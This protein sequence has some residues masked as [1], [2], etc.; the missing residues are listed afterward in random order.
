MIGGGSGGGL[1]E[2]NT[3]DAREKRKYLGWRWWCRTRDDG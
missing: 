2:R 1:V 3:S